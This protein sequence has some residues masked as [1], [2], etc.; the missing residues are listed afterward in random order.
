[1]TATLGRFIPFALRPRPL[2]NG[3]KPA[4]PAG[5][6][7]WIRSTLRRSAISRSRNST[8]RPCSPMRASRRQQRRYEDF[9]I[10]DVDG[11]HSRPISY[12][13]IVEY[14]ED[15]VLRD[16]AQV[17]GLWRRRHHRADRLLPGHDRPRH[18]PRR[19]R[20]GEI[21][22]RHASRHHLYEALDG[23]ARHRSG[24]ALSD[25]DARPAL[26]AAA[27]S[28]GGAGARLQPLALR[29]ILAEEP[30]IKASL[31]LPRTM[32]RRCTRW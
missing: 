21:P 13:Q 20:A 10:V 27:R 11:H 3:P 18:P 30:R 16:Q 29:E 31:Y 32:P 7:L 24:A 23:C 22:R 6:G 15:P 4:Q 19:P 2:F 14:I 17:S 8:P 9:P 26:H 28:R 25:A 12:A 1:M 5:E